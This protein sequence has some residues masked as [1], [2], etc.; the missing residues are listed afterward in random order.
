LHIDTDEVNRLCCRRPRKIFESR[1]LGGS[2]TGHFL[3]NVKDR[4]DTAFVEMWN[5]NKQL[6]AKLS[7]NR[8]QLESHI[9]QLEQHRA[10]HGN[11]I[12]V[13]PGTNIS[14]DSPQLHA[15]I[16][17]LNKLRVLLRSAPFIAASSGV[18][19]DA[20]SS[21][22]SPAVQREAGSRQGE[23]GSGSGTGAAW[24]GFGGG[25]GGGSG[26]HGL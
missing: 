21:S 1:N 10:D 19:L 17:A 26:G 15:H 23:P 14:L 24:Q 12:Y 13:D 8:A 20:P 22:S 25:P 18:N 5:D 11:Q 9:A 7:L 4:F 16:I 2:T 3:Y 6:F